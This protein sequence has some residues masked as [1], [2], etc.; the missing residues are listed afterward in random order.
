MWSCLDRVAPTAAHMLPRRLYRNRNI[1]PAVSLRHLHLWYAILRVYK[2]LN[3]FRRRITGTNIGGRQLK[4]QLTENRRGA[5]TARTESWGRWP[6][7]VCLR[8]GTNRWRPNPRK[9]QPNWK[10]KC[11]DLLWQQ[12]LFPCEASSTFP[13]TRRETGA[14]AARRANSLPRIDTHQLVDVMGGARLWHTWSA[15]C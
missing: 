8:H 1:S 3:A 4:Q 12:C 5:E 10:A 14:C 11:W 2:D 15:L 7:K 13:F 9:I 6:R